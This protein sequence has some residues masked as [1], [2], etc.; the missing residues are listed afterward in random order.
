MYACLAAC[1]SCPPVLA[2]PVGSHRA[3][4]AGAPLESTFSQASSP[5]S[6]PEAA[7]LCRLPTCARR[8]LHGSKL[9]QRPN[10]SNQ[11]HV[12]SMQKPPERMISLPSRPPPPP[13]TASPPIGEPLHQEDSMDSA[14]SGNPFMDFKMSGGVKEASGQLRLRVC[15]C[16]DAVHRSI[17]Q[18]CSFAARGWLD[19]TRG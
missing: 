7:A 1:T 8:R 10:S 9:S 17:D 14:W 6:K 11:V 15:L 3:S 13:P 12:V 19:A 5:Q 16:M 2:D 18:W 4:C